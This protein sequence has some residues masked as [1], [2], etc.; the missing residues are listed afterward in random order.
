MLTTRRLDKSNWIF[1]Y[2]PPPHFWLKVVCKMGGGEGRGGGGGIF[3]G[4]YSTCISTAY[5]HCCSIRLA[6]WCPPATNSDIHDS[7][8]CLIFAFLLDYHRGVGPDWVPS[9]HISPP[10][11]HMYSLKDGCGSC[12]LHCCEPVP[13]LVST[14]RGNEHWTSQR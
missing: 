9:H 1:K 14:S 8:L 11:P 10:H 13:Y 12:V 6:V 5:G 3:S 2:T 7:C 4:G